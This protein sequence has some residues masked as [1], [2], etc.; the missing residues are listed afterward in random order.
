[1]KIL[2]LS[3]SDIIGGA[4]RSAYRI[5]HSLIKQGLNSQMWVNVKSSND[6]TI[7]QPASKIDQFLNLSRNRLIKYTLNKLLKTKNTIIHSPSFLPS[8]WVKHINNSDVDI[9]NLHWIQFEMLSISDIVKIEKPIVWTLHDMWAFCGA[10]HYT[11]DCR[12]KE[13]YLKNNRPNYE[14]GFDLNRWTWQRKK[15]Y[16]KNS[17]HIVTPSTWL[18]KCVSDSDL[19]KNWTVSIIPYAIDTDKWKPLNK[20]MSRK[21]FNLPENVNLIL[22]G[23]PGGGKDP[24]KGYDLLLKALEYLEIKNAE[25][26]IFGQSKPKENQN[27]KIPIHY[28]GEIFDDKNLQEIYSAADVMVV[29]SRQDNLPNT[30]LEAQACGTPVVSFNTG[31]LPD[32]ISH[33]KTGYIAKAFDIKDLA[34]GILWVLDNS[35]NIEFGV[36]SREQIL[37]KFSEK[38]ISNSYED[39]YKNIL[40]NNFNF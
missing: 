38:N 25:L 40:K 2:H 33:Q 17:F 18:A 8:S 31:G 6:L 29:P 13:G 30:A 15:K 36:N 35:E 37:Q 24:R 3:Y 9:V 16:W 27:L 32:I 22:F 12:W 26:V 10:E 7:K 34:K 21:K 5:H 1:M 23:A 4:A 19:M 11:N 28:M 39:I 20:I 14:S